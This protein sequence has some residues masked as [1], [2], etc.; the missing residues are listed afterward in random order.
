MACSLF[1]DLWNVYFSSF[2]Y[3]KGK[4]IKKNLSIFLAIPKLVQYLFKVRK[5]EISIIN[6]LAHIL[7]CLYFISVLHSKNTW[8]SF[9]KKKGPL[10]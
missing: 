9:Q 10:I 2:I 5:P 8:L 6:T 3:I 4:D 1:L 7:S